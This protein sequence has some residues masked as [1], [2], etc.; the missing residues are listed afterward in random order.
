[1]VEGDL[2]CISWFEFSNEQDRGEFL[3]AAICLLTDKS[4]Q[5]MSCG[6]G[7]RVIVHTASTVPVHHSVSII[8]LEIALTTGRPIA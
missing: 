5:V 4:G 3:C 8:A 6:D 2:A 7:N 1:M